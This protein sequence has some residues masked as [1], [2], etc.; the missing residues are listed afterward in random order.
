M[1]TLGELLGKRR[2]RALS[3][4]FKL[5]GM[6]QL[7]SRNKSNSMLAHNYRQS[8]APLLIASTFLLAACATQSPAT[9]THDQFPMARGAYP[10]KT[11]AILPSGSDLAK[12]IEFE[13]A[14]RGFAIA[15]AAAPMSIVTDEDLKAA[16]E[17]HI[18]GRVSPGETEKLMKPFRARGIDA[19]L[20]LKTDGFSPRRWR[21]Y[22]YWQTADVHLYTTHPDPKGPAHSYWGWV[23]IDNTR[24]KSPPEAAS[25]I[26]TRMASFVSNPL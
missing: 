26:V 5:N 20:V 15:T 16:S 4:S 1:G 3:K 14:K 13:L 7:M 24:A 12:A 2:F 11:I 6:R 19:I 23:N 18:P 22:D 25:E 8:I 9:A 21:Q 10:V 17:L